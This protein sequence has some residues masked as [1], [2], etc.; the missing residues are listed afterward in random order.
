MRTVRKQAENKINEF[1]DLIKHAYHWGPAEKLRTPWGA[2]RARREN[3]DTLFSDKSFFQSQFPRFSNQVSILV[4]IQNKI[5]FKMQ[6]ILRFLRCSSHHTL[7]FRRQQTA[8]VSTVFKTRPF[9]RFK[10][11]EPEPE[12]KTKTKTKTETATDKGEEE[13]PLW[14]GN[15]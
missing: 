13:E 7:G 12:T 9:S 3:I 15:G 5:I 1:E 6:N 11:P 4:Q 8:F 14:T 2:A 10:K